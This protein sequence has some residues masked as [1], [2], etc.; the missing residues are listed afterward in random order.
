[1]K[2]AGA[3]GIDLGV[4]LTCVGVVR[5]GKVEIIPNDLGQKTTPSYVAW[6]EHPTRKYHLE[7]V[8]GEAAK[9]E[10]NILRKF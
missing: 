10:V 6:R 7:M 4:S 9:D 3:L 1:M 2:T 8:I 5:D